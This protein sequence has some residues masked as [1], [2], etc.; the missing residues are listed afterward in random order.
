MREAEE[1]IRET[2]ATR[3]S[4]GARVIWSGL[5][6]PLALFTS[7][8]R[9]SRSRVWYWGGESGRKRR[10]EWYTPTRKHKAL[11]PSCLVLSALTPRGHLALKFSSRTVLVFPSPSS[12]SRCS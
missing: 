6:A 9:R 1:W 7:G 5:L 10:E 2:R 3:P 4:A 11:Q 8:F 12:S